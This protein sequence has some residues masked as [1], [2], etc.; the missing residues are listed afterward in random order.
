MVSRPVPTTGGAL[1]GLL[2]LSGGA[3]GTRTPGTGAAQGLG[4]PEVPIG[5][6]TSFIRPS[7]RSVVLMI[8]WKEGITV[9]LPRVPPTTGAPNLDPS[10]DPPPDRYLWVLSVGFNALSP[11]A[12][13]FDGCGRSES[14]GPPHRSA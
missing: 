3:S 9:L 10:G 13:R 2:A 14:G 5:A 1:V 6:A 8:S 7:T 4:L 12:G 11:P